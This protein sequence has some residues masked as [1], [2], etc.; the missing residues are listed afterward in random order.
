M[1]LKL[2]KLGAAMVQW[3]STWTAL[4][5]VL[6]LNPGLATMVSETGYTMS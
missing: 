2:R 5:G 1:T 3:L 6:S 4:Q